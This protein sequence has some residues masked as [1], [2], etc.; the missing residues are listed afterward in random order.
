MEKSPSWGITNKLAHFVVLSVYESFGKLQDGPKPSGHVGHFWGWI[1]RRGQNDHSEL[2]EE[3]RKLVSK[4][5]LLQKIEDLIGQAPDVV[6][7]KI[8]KLLRDNMADIFYERRTGMDVIISEGLLTPLYQ[9]G[10]LMAGI[11][12]QLYLPRSGWSRPFKP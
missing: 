6:E 10:L 7:V 5:L 3:A 1:H 12:P 9:A 4:G 11:Y 8:T 2:T